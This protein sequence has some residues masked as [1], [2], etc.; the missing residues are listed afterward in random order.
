MF[1]TLSL[2]GQLHLA[3]VRRLR[4]NLGVLLGRSR[5]GQLSL[6]DVGHP[7]ERGFRVLRPIHT[8]GSCGDRFQEVARVAAPSALQNP[9]DSG[10]FAGRCQHSRIRAEFPED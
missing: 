7:G 8:V 2:P 9:D 3:L 4:R 5:I 6:P 1:R 10:H